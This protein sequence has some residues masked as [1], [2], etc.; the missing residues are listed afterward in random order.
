MKSNKLLFYCLLL[1]YFFRNSS[2]NFVSA[3]IN[4]EWEFSY[5]PVGNYEASAKS[6]IVLPSGRV[7]VSG[8]YKSSTGNNKNALLLLDSV[9]NFLDVDTSTSGFGYG[10]VIYDGNGNIYAAATLSNDSLP[11][12][13]VV[14]ARFDSTFNSRQFFV[15]DSTT[16]FPGYDV[17][18]MALLSNSS[19]V[20]ASHWDAF[21]F[22]NL[23]LLCM[24]SQ[25]AVLWERVDSSFEFSYDVKLIPDSLGGVFVAGSG[26]DTSLATNFVFISHYTSTGVRDWQVKEYSSQSFADMND[27]IMDAQKNLYVSGVLM[28]STGQVGFLMKLDTVGNVEWNVPVEHLSY[29]KIAADQAGNIYGGIIEQNGIDVV[30]IEKIDSSG[31][32][33][34]SNSYQDS[35]YF[36]SDLGDLKVL[37]SGQIAATGGAYIF[38]FPKYDLYFAVFDT[39]LN[40]L[41]HDY[42]D[43]SNFLGEIG[44]D[45]AEAPGGSVYVCARFNFENQLETS[46]MGVVKYNLSALVNNVEQIKSAQLEVYPNPS[47]GNF[48]LVCQTAKIKNL[49]ILNILGEVVYE[50]ILSATSAE[51]DIHLAIEPGIYFVIVESEQGVMSERVV[52]V[53]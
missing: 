45:M 8:I 39:A 20:V 25:G 15:P 9:G 23:S 30:T 4:R 31:N 24:D 41:A 14:V 7:V 37:E 2:A 17:L 53:E 3:Q 26:R 1:F 6:V 46:N 12:N 16:T 18:D 42:Y 34:N 38:S 22:V 13:K 11:I 27:F 29:V 52:V 49:R 21:P 19:L 48:K 32:L 44:M 36:T 10:K 35:V 51:V 28:D 33:I 50:R 40:V 47:T 5:N 43:S